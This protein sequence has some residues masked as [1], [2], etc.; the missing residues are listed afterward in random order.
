M[1]RQKTP[2]QIHHEREIEVEMKKKNKTILIFI[3]IIISSVA[4][5]M[6]IPIVNESKFMSLLPNLLGILLGGIL[7]SIAIIFGL[8]SSKDLSQLKRDFS[9][10]ET[11]P[12]IEFLKKVKLDTKI[13]FSSL[14]ISTIIF[15]SYDIEYFAAYID[16]RI[17]F[18]FSLILLFC[19]LSSTYDIIMSL[20]YLNELRYEISK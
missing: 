6:F 3:L 17:F 10:Y 14:V 13:I 7:A 18:V 15:V 4:L 20:F 8:L 12:Y 11:N 1:I 9:D 16:P 5:A 19:S 2:R